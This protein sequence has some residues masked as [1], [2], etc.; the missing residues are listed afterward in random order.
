MPN[1]F[2]LLLRRAKQYPLLTSEEELDLARRIERGDLA[3]KERL[4]NSNLLLVIHIAKRYQISESSFA[5]MDLIQE[6]TVGLVRASEKFD[7]RK[8]FRF[9]TYA[10]LWIRQ[11]IGRG[12]KE[13]DRTIRLPV[14]VDDRVRKLERTERELATR[15]G[16]TP[17]DEELTKELEWSTEDLE[18]IRKIGQKALS[19]DTPVGEDGETGM[20]ELLKNETSET[21]EDVVAA[22]DQSER[23]ASVMSELSQRERDVIEHRYMND[24][25]ATETGRKLGM[26]PRRVR[27]IEEIALRRMSEQPELQDFRVKKWHETSF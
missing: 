4:I 22:S 14:H 7:Y 3:A 10:T 20:G 12:L 1:A 15:S 17:S 18:D 13:K 9:S 2:Q 26:T 23:L 16:H 8:G 27:Q 11:A 5:L 24:L 19:L 25:S 6:G 21:P